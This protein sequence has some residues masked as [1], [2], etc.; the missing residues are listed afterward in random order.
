[1]ASTLCSRSPISEALVLRTLCSIHSSVYLE[2]QEVF[3]SF[4]L[5]LAE[6]AIFC[7]Y[8]VE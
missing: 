4:R 3:N 1:M 8:R 2:E 6:R 7:L 5:S